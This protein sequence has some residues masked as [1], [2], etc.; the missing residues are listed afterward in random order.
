MQSPHEIDRMFACR[1]LS[2]AAERRN[3]V[4]KYLICIL[5]LVKSIHVFVAGK[6]IE[7][8]RTSAWEARVLAVY[9]AR[10]QIP[11]STLYVG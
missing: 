8:P 1:C 6:I 10:V 7:A 2:S 5:F 4:L 9:V 3:I 11:A